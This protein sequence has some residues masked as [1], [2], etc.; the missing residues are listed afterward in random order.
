MRHGAEIDLLNPNTSHALLVEL[1][2][3]DRRVLDVGCAAGH[4]GRALKARGC[5]VAGVEIDEAAAEAAAGVLDEVLVGDVDELD[6][7]RHFGKESFDVVVFGDVLDH[8][9]DPV[10][11]LRGVRPL[12]VGTGAVVA[13]IPNVAHGAVRLAMLKGRFEYRPPGLLDPTRVRFFTRGSLYETFREA[14]LAPVDV[15]RTTAGV[16]DTEIDV[17]REEFDEG[18]V[19]AVEGDPESTTY[20]FVLRAVAEDSSEV[21]AAPPLAPEPAAGRSAATVGVVADWDPDDLRTALTVRVTHAELAR[22]V[23]GATWRILAAG[24]R[25]GPGPHDGGLAV[26]VL[27]AAGLPAGLDC[28]VVTGDTDGAG[29]SAARAAECPVAWIGARDGDCPPQGAVA[30]RRSPEPSTAALGPAAGR[31]AGKLP[32]PLLLVPRLLPA[33]ALARRLH[34][35]RMMGWFPPAGAGFVL[36]VDGALAPHVADVAREVDAAASADAAAVVLMTTSVGDDSAS[37]AD[38]IASSLTVPVHRVPGDATVDDIVAVIAHAAGVAGTSPFAT[39]LARAYG[40]PRL[41]VGAAGAPADVTPDLES[42]EDVTDVPA[43][44]AELDLDFD[45]VA[46]FVD[47]S[48]AARPRPSDT[49]RALT[50][51]GYVGALAQAHQRMRERLA[52]ERLAVADHVGRHDGE[53]AALQAR[54]M[55]L[56]NERNE[57]EIRLIQ[58]AARHVECAAELARARAELEALRNVRVLRV[59]RPARAV[60]ARLRGSRL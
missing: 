21:V 31:A 3:P 36:D 50:T 2:G 12:L 55:R 24:P 5:R 20:Q 26:A 29:A 43:V 34:Y 13:S 58:E 42:V 28:V 45:R 46:A 7:V 22:R 53:M 18:V 6:L 41:D 8:V 10:A 44:Q 35:V 51:A 14:G 56:R 1:T 25:A 52:A 4:L 57:L 15:R 54:S 9:A 30:G 38:A 48:A 19:D 33:P 40:V 16:F 47:A 59:L 23:A 11:T 17:R 60:Y 27:G 32:D 49:S 37:V 39:T